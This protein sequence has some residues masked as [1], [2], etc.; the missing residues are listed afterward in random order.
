M[1]AVWNGTDFSLY[2]KCEGKT[3]T[4]VLNYPPFLISENKPLKMSDFYFM[5]NVKKIN[6]HF[7]FPAIFIFKKPVKN[8]V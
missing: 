7:K 6:G 2:G 5:E 4:V 3:L 8:Y 1:Y